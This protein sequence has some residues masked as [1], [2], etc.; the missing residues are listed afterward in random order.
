MRLRNLPSGMAVFD[1]HQAADPELELA[2]AAGEIRMPKKRRTLAPANN[3]EVKLRHT[4]SR[5]ITKYQ[6]MK[7]GMEE[8]D[9][10]AG[11][12]VIP[13]GFADQYFMSP[14]YARPLSISV[15][16][17]AAKRSIQ[18]SGQ[19]SGEQSAEHGKAMAEESK[20]RQRDWL[21]SLKMGFSL[22]VQGV[23]SKWRVLESFADEALAPWGANILRIN[24]FD[25]S[26]SMAEC[27]RDTLQHLFPSAQR[28]SNSPEVLA[29]ILRSALQ[30]PTASA[31]PLC[32]IVHNIESLPSPHQFI[33]ATLAT[34]PGVHLAAS[35]DNIW[36]PLAWTSRCLKDF[37]FCREE[38]HT[39]ESFE[40]EHNMR[41][42]R[43]L[44]GWS[45]P[46]ATRQRAPKASLGLVMRSLTRSH[47]EL[48]QAVAE[49]QLTAEGRVGISQSRLLTI[50]ADRMIAANTAKL[51]GLLNELKDHEVMAQKCAADGGVQLYLTCD[52]K[53][54]KRL[55]EGLEIDD[56]S[57]DDESG[58]EG[59]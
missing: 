3:E 10:E 43:G 59:H 2:M 9:D 54:L 48:V 17:A 40:L 44:P 7:A 24:G 31:R 49:H 30:T 35:I 11:L 18:V 38:V 47:R 55:A 16:R 6:G 1:P 53:T 13:T 57:G 5:L 27:L 29:S 41:Y 46:A 19:A 23:G 15:C 32:F 14:A 37:N 21:G 4:Y 39:F 12:D 50:A 28:T 26:F 36:A 34:T 58:A 42:S 25:A 8:S 20:A 33:L 22:L 51:R 45:N 56:E 52:N